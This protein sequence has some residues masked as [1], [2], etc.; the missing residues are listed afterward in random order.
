MQNRFF[1]NDDDAT[2][3]DDFNQERA[4]GFENRG[5][6]DNQP[7]GDPTLQDDQPE[8]RRSRRARIPRIFFQAG[9]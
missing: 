6:E 3:S 4:R 9:L 1:N 5:A 7:A 2:P 8:T